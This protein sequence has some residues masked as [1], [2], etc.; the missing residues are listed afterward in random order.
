MQD[1]K[2]SSLISR[3]KSDKAYSSYT[4]ISNALDRLKPVNLPIMKVAIL[5]NFTIEPVIP[6]IRGEIVLEGFYPEIYVGDF[7]NIMQNVIEPQ[8]GLY[9]FQPDLIIIA[10]WFE[11][12]SAKLALSYITLSPEEIAEEVER[13]IMDFKNIIAEIRKSSTVPI[14]INNFPLIT[15]NTLGILDTQ[16]DI[17]QMGTLLDINSKLKELAKNSSDVYIVDYFKLIYKLGSFHSVEERYW[18]MSRAPISRHGIVPLGQEYGKFFRAL[19]GRT[20]KCLVLDCDE[21]LWGGII[22]EAGLDGIKLGVDYPGSCYQ[23][24]QREIINLY[25]KGVILAL[26]SKNN[27]EDV[28]EV[29]NNHPGMLL[30]EEHFATWQINWSDK[31]SNI[32]KIAETLNIGLDSLVFVDDSEF[33]CNQVRERLP[34]VEVIHLPKEPSSYKSMLSVRGLFDTLVY[35]NEDRLRNKTYKDNIQRKQ[36]YET[37][38]TLEEY[39]TKLN[40][41]VEIGTPN[42]IQLPRVSQLTQKT[43]QFNLTTFRYTEAEIASLANSSESDV[44]Y[45]KLHDKV[46]DLGII[47]VAILKYHVGIAVEIDSFL[48]SCRALGR[49]IENILL[50]HLFEIARGKGYRSIIGRY[51]PTK[52]NA[53]VKDFYEKHN[54][55]LKIQNNGEY[56]WEADLQKVETCTP[57]YIKVTR[58]D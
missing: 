4:A 7:D 45:I 54:F 55:K 15:N 30:R 33:E 49:S 6:V 34:Q 23:A 35:T 46:S 42:T 43:N 27:E 16:N 21:T 48:L 20:R 2:L 5:R 9:H 53:Q 12:V 40:M 8:S 11:S 14:L 28:I 25:H 39:L 29:L 3:L 41:E 56:I 17:S 26:C 51:I 47:G 31:V 36:I 50:S 44:F 13:I 32:I 38:G 22:G 10:Q 52:K 58:I 1:S 37:S 57:A 18:H 19:K 24:F